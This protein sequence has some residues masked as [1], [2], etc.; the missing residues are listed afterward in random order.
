MWNP[1]HFA[2]YYQNFDL[3]KYFVKEMKINM[4]ITGM[5]SNA[6]HEKDA[7]NNDRYPEDKLMALLLAYDRRNSQI[8]K[9]LLDEGYK[10]WPSKCIDMLLN[11]RLFNDIKEWYENSNRDSVNYKEFIN[12][13][14]MLV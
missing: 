12:M 3:V 13:W 4:P 9:F 7:V 10:I 1:L 11:E 2:I 6:D 5:K 8:L 14:S